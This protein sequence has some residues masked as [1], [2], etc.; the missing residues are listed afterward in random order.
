MITV[1]FFK[2]E[3]KRKCMANNCTHCTSFHS[4]F[5]PKMPFMTVY[6]CIPM[7]VF[8][9]FCYED[10]QVRMFLFARFHMPR[11]TE[12]VGPAQQPLPKT[13]HCL[14]LIW[15]RIWRRRVPPCNGRNGEGE[16]RRCLLKRVK[17]L[18]LECSYLRMECFGAVRLWGKLN[19]KSLTLIE[20]ANS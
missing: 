13:P 6:S 16:R 5:L 20:T 8:N 3:Q 17:H 9:Y 10:P 12:S 15:L 1:L 11:I 19:C 14:D 2:R 7:F 18:L 4:S